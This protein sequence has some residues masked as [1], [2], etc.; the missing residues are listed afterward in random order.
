MELL[1]FFYFM[2]R[3]IMAFV[4]T[5]IVNDCGCDLVYRIIWAMLEKVVMM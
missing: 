4:A 5:S 1:K 3:Q 2:Q